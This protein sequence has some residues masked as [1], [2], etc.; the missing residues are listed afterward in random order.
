MAPVPAPAAARTSGSSGDP[1]LI[2]DSPPHVSFNEAD[3]Q[4]RQGFASQRHAPPL[5]RPQE[6]PSRGRWVDGL[7]PPETANGG[8]LLGPRNSDLNNARL[9]RDSMIDEYGEPISFN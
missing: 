9:Q 5:A 4:P 2:S 1:I 6:G 3:H 8:G 7:V